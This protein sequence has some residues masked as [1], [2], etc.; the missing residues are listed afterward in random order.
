MNPGF[1]FPLAAIISLFVGI[2]FSLVFHR[3]ESVENPQEMRRVLYAGI[4]TAACIMLF[5][6]VLFFIAGLLADRIFDARF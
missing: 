3:N 6:T 1:F 2:L 4:L 5:Y